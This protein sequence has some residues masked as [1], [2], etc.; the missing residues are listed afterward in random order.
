MS[1]RKKAID[2]AA[3]EARRFLATVDTLERCG[4]MFIGGK[5]DSWYCG[6][7][8]CAAVKRASMDLSR[9]LVGVRR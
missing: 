3:E 9:A 7:Q 5:N 2:K 1:I 4:A 6:G 8:D